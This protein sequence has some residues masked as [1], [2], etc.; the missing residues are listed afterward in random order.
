MPTAPPTRCT[1]PGC[2]TLTTTGRCPEHQRKPWANPSANTRTLTGAQRRTIKD[3]QLRREP[4]CRACHATTELE[5]DHIIELADGGAIFDPANLQTLCH[6]C[7]A[8]KT[9]AAR[10]ERFERA[11]YGG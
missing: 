10:T 2:G 8:I 6:D 5:A 11:S 4:R 9:A 7:H 1:E 3:Q